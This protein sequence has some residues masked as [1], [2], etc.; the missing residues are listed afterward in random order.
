MEKE[1]EERDEK[2]SQCAD[3]YYD[4][5]GDLAD[6]LLEFIMINKDKINLT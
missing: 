6:P 3:Q 4:N 2:L 1:N 5:A